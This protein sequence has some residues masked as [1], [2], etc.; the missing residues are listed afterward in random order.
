MEESNG[1]LKLGVYEEILV[2]QYCALH[3]K[4]TPK[5]IPTICILNIKQNENGILICAK[6]G[7]VVLGNLKQRTWEKGEVYA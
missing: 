3:S 7:I 4:G 1:L 2:E 6:R 5:A